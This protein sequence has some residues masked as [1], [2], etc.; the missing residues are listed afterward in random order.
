MHWT[1]IRSWYK[2]LKELKQGWILFYPSGSRHSTEIQSGLLKILIKEGWAV[3]PV[4]LD[5]AGEAWSAQ[6]KC[7]KPFHPLEVTVFEPY[8]GQN[9]DE[10]L[11][12]LRRE[13]Y[14]NEC[15]NQA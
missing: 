11:D 6:S 12:K 13:L 9:L 8:K 10:L 4:R 15:T 5:G 3:L 2:H 1:A 7:W 14:Q